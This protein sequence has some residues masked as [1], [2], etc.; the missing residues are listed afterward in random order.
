MTIE[1]N[2]IKKIEKENKQLKE[3]LLQSDYVKA[4]VFSDREEYKQQI[5]ELNQR[6]KN[7]VSENTNLQNELFTDQLQ[8]DELEY[9]LLE[10]KDEI[11]NLKTK[12]YDANVK[13]Q[14]LLKIL[15]ETD[16]YT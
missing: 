15:N 7:L 11:I 5:I 12:L 6:I 10:L 2:Y 4:S 13:E 16:D 9:K 3:E 14:R 1:P 8:T